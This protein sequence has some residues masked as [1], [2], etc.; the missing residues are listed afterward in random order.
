MINHTTYYNVTYSDRIRDRLGLINVGDRFLNMSRS[1][2]IF[3]V[4]SN[5]HRAF[6][7]MI[8]DD[9]FRAGDRGNVLTR[10]ISTH[11]TLNPNYFNSTVDVD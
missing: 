2:S 5:H 6:I 9:Y 7:R 10:G 11:E 4:P 1:N 8:R 3:S